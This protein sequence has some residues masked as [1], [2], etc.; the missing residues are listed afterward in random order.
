MLLAVL[1]AFGAAACGNPSSTEDKVIAFPEQ[2]PQIQPATGGEIRMPMPTNADITDPLKV[3]TEEMLSFFSLIFESLISINES[4]K[5]VATLAENWSADETG[6]IWTV[7]LRSGIYWSDGT[8]LT[9]SDVNLTFSRLKTLGEDSYYNYCTQKIDSI[10]VVDSK[11]LKVTMAEKGYCALYALT[12]PI[13]KNGAAAPTPIGT[14]PYCVTAAASQRVTLT[15]NENWWKQRPYIDTIVFLE[16]DSNE[17]ALASYGAGQLSM[18]HTSSTSAGKYREEGVT[19]VLDIMTQNVELMLLNSSTAAL[20]D[21]NVRKAIAY[22][23]DRSKIIS[24]VYMNRAQAC[25]VPVPPDSWVYDDKSKVYDYNIAK[26]QTLLQDAGWTD[27]DGDGILE[28]DGN[29]YDKFKLTLLVN[30]SS[31]D[32]TRK[33]AAGL[34]ASQLGELGIQAEVVT[35]A[36]SATDAQSEFLTKLRGGEYD[37][38]L[39]GIKLGRDADLVDLMTYG[40]KSNY[41]NYSNAALIT[42]ASAIVEAAD[43][44]AYQEAASQFQLKFVEELPFITLYFRLNS[45]IYASEIQN[46]SG[47]RDPNMMRNVDKWYI[48]T[49]GNDNS[50]K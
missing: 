21:I 13:M 5:L 1:F 44:T 16:R 19:T 18:V 45:I 48:N 30:E 27:V 23:L 28:K 31:T 22:A 36:Y 33:D 14:G 32:T 7:N 10:E 17:T 29:Q 3:N 11:T 40:G 42:L 9:A 8:P 26:A 49:A 37:L 43:E 2:T 25:D 38:A 50:A 41:G 46:V 20:Q 35:A 12:F 6:R 47:A 24:N 39:I 4:G 34:I 15:A